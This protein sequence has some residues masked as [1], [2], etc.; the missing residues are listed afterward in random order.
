MRI[1][2]S[3]SKKP[4]MGYV[5]LVWPTNYFHSGTIINLE[6]MPIKM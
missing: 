6:K 1:E 4:L 5:L 2:I 3:L